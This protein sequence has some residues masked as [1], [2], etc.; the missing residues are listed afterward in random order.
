MTVVLDASA[1][2]ALLHDEP[3]AG[4][5]LTLLSDAR[6]SAVNHAEVL[7]RLADAGMPESKA[8]ELIN[9]LQIGVEPFNRSQSLISGRLRA[10]TRKV[11]LSLGDRAC[12][13]LA[14]TLGVTA[15]TADRAWADLDLDVEVQL[16]R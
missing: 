6:L 11:G 3:G 4:I 2:L 1:V 16:I 13:A 9:S 12:L 10:A 15:V 7:A 5:V 14:E 8:D